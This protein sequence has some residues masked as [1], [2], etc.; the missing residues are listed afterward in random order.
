MADKRTRNATISDVARL[1][2]VS[3]KTV[4][5]VF[6]NE[7][8]VSEDKKRKI[9][10]IADQLNYRPS[11]QARGLAGKKSYMVALFVDKL[12]G[13]YLTKV[14]R[15]ILDRSV[16]AGCHLVIEVLPKRG[17]RERLRQ[18]LN[19]LNLDGAVLA[20]PI[21]DDI[22]VLEALR[23]SQVP[24]VRI[25][26]G[27]DFED[28]GKVAIDEALA[29]TE[30]VEFLIDQGHDRIGFIKGDPRHASSME[31]ERGYLQALQL[32]GLPIEN[33]LIRQGTFTFESGRVA[34]EELLSTDDPPSAIFASNDEMALAVLA[35]ARERGIAIPEELSVVGFDDSENATIVTPA[36]TTIHQPVISMAAAAFDWLWSLEKDHDPRQ[37]AFVPHQHGLRI[38]DSVTRKRH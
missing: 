17:D 30:I 8:Y 1:A 16:P 24:T 7:K 29:A 26:P 22:V 2:G 34:A 38:R 27:F 19:S 23:D 5:R 12:E 20:A 33:R 18:V 36:L 37:Q 31:R 14:M 11:L 13:D 3:I 9:L 4:S 25:G 35:V 21:C 15:G 28:S 6:N 10:E 32:H